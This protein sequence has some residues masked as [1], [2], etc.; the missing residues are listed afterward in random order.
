MKR[1][2]ALLMLG[3]VFAAGVSGAAMSSLSRAVPGAALAQAHVSLQAVQH[4]ATAKTFRDLGFLSLEEAGRATLGAP[5]W[6]YMVRLD[7][8]SRYKPNDDPAELLEDKG[9]VRYLVLVGE[10]VRTGVVVRKIGNEWTVESAGRPALTKALAAAATSASKAVG[11]AP[12]T[13]FVVSIP[14]L[15]L[16]FVGRVQEGRLVLTSA[17]NAPQYGVKAGQTVAASE[18]FAQLSEF[19]KQHPTGPRLTD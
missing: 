5:L 2:I 1:S 13:Q 10:E 3:M 17:V 4:L 12:T 19:A 15:Q 6:D 14:A 7:R 8:L 11:A 18:L 9:T 16:Y